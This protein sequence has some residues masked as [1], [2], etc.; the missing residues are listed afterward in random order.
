LFNVSERAVIYKPMYKVTVQNLKTK[1]ETA[2][3]IDAITG[4]T[5]ECIQ[6]APD[7]LKKEPAKEPAKPSI[8]AKT[9][10]VSSP[11]KKT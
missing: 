2:L 8:S 9:A 11:A 3:I 4:K 7:P 1:K 6:Q 10:Q 5:K